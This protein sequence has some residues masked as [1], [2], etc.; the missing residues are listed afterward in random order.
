MAPPTYNASHHHIGLKEKGTAT[1]YGFMLAG[2]YTMEMQREGGGAPDF[3]GSMD[4]MGAP[5]SMSRWTQ[6]DFVGGAFAWQWGKDDAMFA[7]CTGFIPDE[8]GRGLLSCPPMFFKHAFD[9]D[10]KTDWT[11]DIP[12]SLFFV[13]NSI[14]ICWNHGILRYRID[15]DAETWEDHLPTSTNVMAEYNPDDNSIWQLCNSSVAAA[16]CFVRRLNLD[17]SDPSFDN[18]LVGP[19][20]TSDQ[21]A[22]GGTIKG[23]EIVC[24]I[25]RYLWAGDPPEDPVPTLNGA[26]TWRKIGRLP[27]RWKDSTPYQGMTYI[28]LNDGADS[29]TYATSLVAYDGDSILPICRFPSSFYGKCM[30]D[31]AGRLFVGGT[32]TDIN[33]SEQYAELYEV[34]GASVRKVR[35]FSPETRRSLMSAGNW[36]RSI[37]DL[38]VHE[39]LLWMCQRGS[40]MVVYDVTSDGFFGAS[41]ILSNTDFTIQKMV[42]GRG[43]LW[44]FGIDEGTDANHGIYRIAQAADTV[45][46]WNA[47][48]V[49]SDF[50]YEPGLKKRWGDVRVLTR[51]GPVESIEY[52]LD[53]G[54]NWTALTVSNT[55]VNK[56]YTSVANMAAIPTAT[57]IRFR[58]KL[59]TTTP[60]SALTYH[61]E[62]VAYTVTFAILDRGLR[63]WGLTINASEFIERRDGEYDETLVVDQTY[64]DVA[65]TIE[66]WATAG[67]PLTMTDLDGDTRDVQIVAFRKTSPVITTNEAPETQPESHCTITLLEVPSA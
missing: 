22:Y 30:I 5:P 48:L 14:Y 53:S 38:C 64:T 17:L 61:R 35:T 3:G 24:Q 16:E 1:M 13:G 36:P 52:S 21:D 57:V 15:T 32:G 27:G 31:Y 40:R 19:S 59:H 55:N 20:S 44:G 47:T 45:A 26:M 29:P 11:T 41:E 25:G 2:A 50:V 37:E 56:V 65:N 63:S 8:Q 28:L 51:Y 67:T 43:R 39:G 18:I 4:L 23:K 6:D 12:R 9:P 34:T 42:G 10:T 62:L 54:Q 33:G 66:E 7:D 60:D 58:F 46:T 49:T